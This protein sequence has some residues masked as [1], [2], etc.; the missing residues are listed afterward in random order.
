MSA[1]YS[2]LPKLYYNHIVLKQA[3][4]IISFMFSTKIH[5]LLRL[6]LLAATQI[7]DFENDGRT[8]FYIYPPTTFSYVA[9]QDGPIVRSSQQISQQKL[10]EYL[11]K[12]R[13]QEGNFVPRNSGVSDGN[14]YP[15]HNR[16]QKN[17]LNR[18]CNLQLVLLRGFIL[19]PIVCLHTLKIYRVF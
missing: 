12:F 18:S 3:R 19:V 15:R 10:V 8:Y 11:F 9:K 7:Y 2:Q 16:S 4:P 17:Q 5:I 6:L 14:L 13:F 1:E